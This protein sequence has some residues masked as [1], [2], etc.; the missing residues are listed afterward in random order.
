MITV[1]RKDTY[2]RILEKLKALETVSESCFIE[3]YPDGS[4]AVVRYEQQDGPNGDSD[5][6]ILIGD[7]KADLS[8]F[9]SFTN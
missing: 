1:A 6:A 5:Y 4:F 2:D 9:Y 3:L 7:S 8:K